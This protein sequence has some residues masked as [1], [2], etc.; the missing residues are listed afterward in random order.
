[1]EP[2]SLSQLMWVHWQTDWMMFGI[3]KCKGLRNRSRSIHN[4]PMWFQTMI[5]YQR[6]FRAENMLLF[7]SPPR[8]SPAYFGTTQ[9]SHKTDFNI[10]EVIQ[11]NYTD[12]QL[13]LNYLLISSTTWGYIKSRIFKGHIALN[14]LFLLNLLFT[15]VI[16]TVRSSF[17]WS[18]EAE[19]TPWSSEL[20]KFLVFLLYPFTP[21][22][23]ITE[24]FKLKLDTV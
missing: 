21:L 19:W 13:R 6:Q 8:C 9:H 10:T 24:T 17:Y 1:M 7:G 4:L 18:S 3:Y 16:W 15:S 22:P 20:L 5:V 23:S 14:A 12:L 2:T 11:I